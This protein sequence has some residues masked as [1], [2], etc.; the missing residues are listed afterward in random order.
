[1]KALQFTDSIPRYAATKVIGR[2]RPAVFWSDIACLRYVEVPPPRL[3][4]PEW[5]RVATRYGGIC[6]SDVGLVTL[7]SS[8]SLSP[9]LSF[10]FTIGHEN[11]GRVS[12]LG[13]AVTGFAHGQRVVVD[14][15]LG[16]E[17]R[18]IDPVCDRCARG[19]RQLCRRLRDGKIAPGMMT[20]FCRDT[21]GSWSPSFVAHRSQLVPV[22]ESVS[23]DQAVLAE[24]FAVALHA[25]LR[26]RPRDDQTVLVLGSGVIG[27]STIAA[28]RAVG[29]RARVIATARHP[30]QAEM[31]TRLGA[32]VVIRPKRGAAFYRQ[33]A[34]ITGARVLKPILGKHV[35]QGGAD[36]IFECVGSNDTVDD[37]L[38]LADAGATVVLVGLAGVPR[39]IDWTPIWFQE[40]HV[41]GTF[42]Y[43]IEEFDGERLSTMQL[44][45]RLMAEGKADLAPLLTHCFPL[46]DYR[47]ALETVT[48]KGSSGVIKAAFAFEPDV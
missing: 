3:P 19:D 16:C 28:L 14:P 32:D 5:V 7:H 4:S 22:P 10:P 17:A 1:M 23:D 29:S 27:L 8:T 36:L 44:A 31:A 24:P 43:G 46:E 30:F 42:A 20:G 45:V 11:V 13:S 6:G 41:R 33:V 39:G 21:G 2:R 38:R 18:Q 25:V 34:E 26:N 48:R 15:M 12:E 47:P 40:I 35:V 9:F 37:A